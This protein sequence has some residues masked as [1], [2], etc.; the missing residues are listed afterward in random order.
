MIIYNLKRLERMEEYK[1][2]L[3]ITDDVE[4]LEELIEYINI[5]KGDYPKIDE[6]H[7]N[8]KEADAKAK[9]IMDNLIPDMKRLR[10]NYLGKRNKNYIFYLSKRTT[11]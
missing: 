5:G 6:M 9:N 11:S 8:D 1:V 10:D 4:A 2:D 3:E 7:T